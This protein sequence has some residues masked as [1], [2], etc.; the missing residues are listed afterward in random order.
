MATNLPSQARGTSRAGVLLEEDKLADEGLSDL[1]LDSTQQSSSAPNQ[2]TA[3]KPSQS[4]ALS[5]QSNSQSSGKSDEEKMGRQGQTCYGRELWDCLA[6]LE[7]S[8]KTRSKQMENMKELFVAVRKG[9]ESFSA[10]V[11]HST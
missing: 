10:Q 2:N 1:N 6:V 11:T 5:K 8:T 9:L 3:S 7:K 4:L